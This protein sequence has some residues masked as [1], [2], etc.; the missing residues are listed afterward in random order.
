MRRRLRVVSRS[1][2]EIVPVTL[3]RR[4]LDRAEI[5]R[6]VAIAVAWAGALGVAWVLG[7]ACSSLSGWESLS[8]AVSAVSNI[9]PNYVEPGKFAQLGAGTKVVYIL[10]MVAGRLEVLPFLLIFSRRMWR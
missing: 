9:G 2:L 4:L 7:T 6:T 1:H 3:N 5:D 10:A 8:A